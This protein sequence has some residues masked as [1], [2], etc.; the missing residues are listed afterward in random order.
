MK[1][2]QITTKNFCA[3]VGITE[4]DQCIIEAAPILHKFISRPITDLEKWVNKIGGTI[5]LIDEAD[6]TED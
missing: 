1:W 3:A 5:T 6:I 2:Y 4:P